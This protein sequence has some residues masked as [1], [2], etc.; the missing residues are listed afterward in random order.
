M[1]QRVWEERV[2]WDDPVIQRIWRQWRS[3]LPS[4]V[5]K[6]VPRCYFPKHVQVVSLQIHGFSDASEDAYAS[7]VYF[8]MVDSAGVV[9]ISLVMAKTKVSPIKRLSIPR[10][11]LCGA[12]VLAKLLHHVREV[13]KVPLSDVHAWTDSTIVL[14]WLVGNPR[15]FKTY[16]GNRVSEIVDRLPPDRWNHVVGADNPADCASR[17]VLPLQLLEHKLWWTGPRWLSLEP[18]QWPKKYNMPVAELPAEEVCM[19]ST[20]LNREPVLSVERYSTFTRV[21][22]IMAW[23][24]RFVS[25]CRPSKRL[26]PAVGRSCLAMSELVV[27]ERYLVKYSQETYF[28]GESSSLRAGKGLPRGSSLLPLH[29][30]V[31]L[32]GIIRVGGRERNSSLGYSQMHPILL[33]GKHCLTRLIVRSEHLRMLHAGPTLVLSSLSRRFH[34]LAM[35]N[36]VRSVIRQCIVCRRRS[37]RPSPQMLGQLPQERVTPGSVFEKV[38]VDYAGP[39]QVKYGVVRK[40]VTVKAYIC[41][42]VSLAVKAVHLEA[43]SDLTSEAFIAALRRFVARRGSPTLIWSDNGTNFVGANRE[44]KEMYNFLSQQEA[45]RAITD[46]CTSLGIEWRFIPEHAPHFGGLWEAAVKSTKTHLRR[47]VGE[48]KLTFEELSTVL[49]QIEA[50]LNSRPLVPVN[51]PDEDSIEVLTPGHFLIGQPL[52]DPSSSHRPIS[53]LKRWDLCQNLLRHFWQR[54]SA[55]YLTSLNKFSKWQNPT[56]NLQVGDVVVLQEDNLVPTKWPLARVS[57]V[58]CGKDGLIRVATVKT[59]KGTYKRPVTKLAPLILKTD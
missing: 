24:L 5:H 3:E 37:T 7:V 21:Q 45:A 8:R 55:E 49:A 6:D 38:G 33:H 48:V 9:H 50:C 53:L 22:R 35:K 39:L 13:F 18:S 4:L 44:L 25:N 16:V 41:I 31:D 28:A 23:I 43:V 54:W 1:L 52:P 59:A 58:H 34:I 12:Q 11:E 57:Q 32:D 20:T 17:G 19:T 29:P 26:V 14:D 15:R 51:T 47:V 40:P 36:T 27:A 2:D 46:V 56:R 30:F 42:F 10:L